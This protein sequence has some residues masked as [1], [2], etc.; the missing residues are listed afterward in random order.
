MNLLA[1]GAHPDDIE[2]CA[3][4]TLAKYSRQGHKVFMATSTNGNMGS[5]TLSME[6][7]AKARKQEVKNSANIKGSKA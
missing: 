5:S 7:I 4:G 6:E 1:I 2:I 3:G